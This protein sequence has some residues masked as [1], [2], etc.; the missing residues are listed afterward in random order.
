MTNKPRKFRGLEYSLNKQD[1]Y[2][3]WLN[4]KKETW[5]TVGPQAKIILIDLL[6][7]AESFGEESARKYHDELELD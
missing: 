3:A 7:M 4:T 6:E 1:F 5:A 2:H